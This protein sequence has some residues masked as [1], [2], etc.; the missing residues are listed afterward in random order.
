MH[1]MKTNYSK[2]LVLFSAVL[3]AFVGHPDTALAQNTI[4]FSP[5]PVLFTASINNQ[6]LQTK[7][8]VVTVNGQPATSLSGAGSTPYF[9]AAPSATP[10]VLTVIANPQGLQ[11][12]TY[13]GT[14]TVT[15]NGQNAPLPV[16]LTVYGSN[17]LTL[18]SNALRFD[19]AANGAIPA[20]QT[21]TVNGSV[22]GIPI[23]VA[24]NT[25]NGGNWLRVAQTGTAVPTSL[26]ITADPTGLAAGTYN[27]TITVAADQVQPQTIAV[28][29]YV[30]SQPILV[31][32]PNPVNL[33]YQSGIGA[34]APT[35]TIDV[36]STVSAIAYTGTV[37]YGNCGPFFSVNSGLSGTTNSQLTLAVNLAQVGANTLCSGSITFTAPGA[38]NPSV[39]IPVNLQVSTLPLLGV[40]PT[41]ANFTYSIGGIF[42]G[43]QTFQVTSSNGSTPLNFSVS[44]NTPFLTVPAVPPNGFATPGS[45]T[46][47]L[48]PSVLAVMN[49]GN[50]SGAVTI[51]AFGSGNSPVTIPVNLTI[52]NNPLVTVSPSFVNFNY[53]T[54]TAVPPAVAVNLASTMGS[55]PYTIA[56]PSTTVTQFVA[57]SP[58]SGNATT[59]ATPLTI[60]LV[61]SVVANLAPGTYQNQV[62]IS[63]G[64]VNQLLTVNLTVS[65]SPL[66]NV[67]PQQLV[68]TYAL[69]GAQP[70]NQTLTLTSTNGSAL[71]VTLTSNQPFLLVG[72]SSLTT[73]GL[74]NVSVVTSGLSAGTF[75]GQITVTSGTQ[76]QIVPVTL[77]VT[78]GITLSATPATLAFVQTAGGPAPAS[79]TVTVATTGNANLGYSVTSTT[80]TGGSWLTVNGSTNGILSGTGPGTFTVSANGAQLSPGTYSGTVLITAVGATNPS[81]T[82]PVTLTVAAQALLLS[83]GTPLTFNAAVQGAVP[84]S[85]TINVTSGGIANLP[86]SASAQTAT[87]GNWLTVSPTSATTPAAVTVSVNQA[88]LAAGT[89]TGSVTLT[90]TGGAPLVVPV[91]LVV[92]AQTLPSLSKV[93]NAASAVNGPVAPG[94]IVSLFGLNL[95]PVTPVGLALTPQGNVATNLGNV[96]VLFDGIPAPLT[97]VSATQINAIVPY[98][99]FGRATTNVVVNFNGVTA[100]ALQLN[101]AASTPGIF[102]V[103][104]TG[105]GQ[106]A[107]LNQ[108]SSLNGSSNAAAKGSIIV[109]YATG[110]GQT[111]P[112]GVTGTVGGVVPK[113]PVGAVSV[114]V[115]GLPATVVYAGSVNGLVSG[116]IQVNA[117]IPAGAPSG[118]S[119]PVV[120]TVGGVSSQTNATIAIQ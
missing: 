60:S 102:T 90:T 31:V 18:S 96:Q 57:F 21:V 6:A 119:V 61:P 116:V 75:T 101:V 66:V 74:A 15:A 92:S 32:T 10:G 24:T 16:T 108:N 73:P 55:L 65:A 115:G 68:F 77:T 39:T 37:A 25:T 56:V 89:Y 78:S 114:T 117:V 12:G 83:P 70:A 38:S 76:T 79:Q 29:L 9:S 40:S 118:A 112:A 86:F 94:E 11:P 27:G 30:S 49:P 5:T 3:M 105:A 23:T 85:Q 48:N 7:D 36:Q 44:T 98:E 35:A 43:P 72:P 107:A 26:V 62:Q 91:T 95:G 80:N 111:N 58:A 64:G 67:N 99:V 41:V 46:I 19:A 71:P 42:P 45:F 97:Y 13:N 52:S 2:L 22:P 20:S 59:T 106:A 8:V 113:F 53:Q 100:T 93:Q 69:N 109:L 33:L 87:G 110:E 1:S 63:G 17:T 34:P 4:A 103:T 104:G 14:V 47:A 54:G 82:I 88:G 120:I 84:A 28:T 81:V 51:S 50:Y